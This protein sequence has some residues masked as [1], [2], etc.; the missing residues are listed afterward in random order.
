MRKN[1]LF[2][3]K[4]GQGPNILSDLVAK[5]LLKHGYYAFYSRDYQSIIRGGHNFNLVSLSDNPISSNHHGI[6]IMVALDENT[7]IVHAK[8]LNKGCIVLKKGHGN[9]YYAGSI[10][11]ILGIDFSILDGL[12]KELKR[13]Y[14]EN[15]KEAKEGYD[16]TKE[17]IDLPKLDDKKLTLMNGNQ[18]I[19]HG[20]IA[21]GLEYYYAYPMTPAT[22][23]LTDLAQEMKNP[24]NKHI[25]IEL[26]N[27][28]AIINAAIGSSIVGGKS[29]IGTSGGGFDLMTEGLSLTGIAEV[30]LVLYLSQR[31]G[32]ATGVPTYSGQGDLKMALGAGH[33]EFTRIVIAPGSPKES[34][35]LTNQ[36]FYLSQKYRVPA[37]VLGDKD[38][39]ESKYSFT[40]NPKLLDAKKSI[41]KLMRFNSYE[42]DVEGSATD[43]PEEIISEIDRRMKKEK[44]MKKEIEKME[45]YKVH[46]KKDSKN[47]VVSWGSPKGAIHDA[48]KHGK[49]DVKFLQIIYLEPFSSKIKQELE[50]AKNIIL[51]E[52]SVTGYLAEVIAQ[53]TQIVIPDK[54]KI[55]KYD[56]RP[57]TSTEIETEVKKRLK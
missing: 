1:I 45:T 6:D 57:F 40:N 24:K 11:K 26:E 30:P 17:S 18:G 41:T 34:I 4:A 49:L 39:A 44:E 16:S 12:L 2:G 10:F 20:A 55:L 48:I 46:G 54:N 32:P 23:V 42:K 8:E 22:G 15:I 31:P 35:D 3:G 5:G 43:I 53:H 38:L 51:V 52:N 29:M 36:A 19:A 28:I 27:E 14:E 13:K 33:G 25:T 7:E 50:K 47:L 56:G 37:I 21:S 9:M